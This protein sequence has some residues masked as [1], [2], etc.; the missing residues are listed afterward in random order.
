[1]EV[2]FIMKNKFSTILL[3][4]VTVICSGFL[5]S[6]DAIVTTD[7]LTEN[8]K[9]TFIA[10]EKAN[11][12][13]E[14]SVEEEIVYFEELKIS[15]NG[16]V[17]NYTSSVKQLSNSLLDSELYTITNDEGTLT[18]NETYKLFQAYI[19]LNKNYIDNFETTDIDVNSYLVKFSISNK[20]IDEAY[21]N[22]IKKKIKGNIKVEILIE[23]D[24]IKKYQYNYSLKDGSE[25]LFV[26]EF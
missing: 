24:L 10:F 19:L 11:V 16:T 26:C 17:N 8:F 25:V 13:T 2:R 23:N 15:R 3:T 20:N 9:M 12:K 22:D 14:I 18:S 6:R 4:L 1:M 21:G 7:T 5:T